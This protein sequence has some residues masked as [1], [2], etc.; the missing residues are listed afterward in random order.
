MPGRRSSSRLRDGEEIP[1][2]VLR[3]EQREETLWISSVPVH[4]NEFPRCIRKMISSH[5]SESGKHRKAAILAAFL[6]QVGWNREEAKTLWKKAVERSGISE[7]IFGKWFQGLH[8]PLCATMIKESKGYPAMGI[9][10]LGYCVP[11][12]KCSQFNSPVEYAAGL[13]TEE[14]RNKGIRMTIL[15]SNIAHVF[16][17]Q[18]GREVEIELT[19]HERKGL[20]AL[21]AECSENRSKS[22]I[23]TIS[24][25]RGRFRPKFLIRQ[26][27]EPSGRLLSEI[28]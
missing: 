6:G 12:Q 9:A 3:I 1:I 11:D 14:D 17:W 25:V 18:S 22:I 20:E 2:S 13:R 19:G 16:N 10:G 8:C 15:I 5:P 4:V 24:K 27:R 26:M 28:I 23:F 21:L 7:K